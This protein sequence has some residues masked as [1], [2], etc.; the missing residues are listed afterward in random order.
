MVVARPSARFFSLSVSPNFGP[1]FSNSW[2]C[3]HTPG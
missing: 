1:T 2:W 3:F